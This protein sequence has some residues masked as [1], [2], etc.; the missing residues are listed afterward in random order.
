MRRLRTATKQVFSN[1][2]AAP[3]RKVPVALA[4]YLVLAATAELVPVVL[5]A[6][7]SVLAA[8]AVPVESAVLVESAELEPVESV[9]LAES[10]PTAVSVALV[11]SAVSAVLELAVLV[12]LADYL[13]LAE[14]AEPVALELEPV[15]LVALV[16]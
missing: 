2:L 10:A 5:A 3:R 4:D 14:T 8:M 12:A 7:C 11:E 6:D 13:V 1:K 9:A 15:V 16:V